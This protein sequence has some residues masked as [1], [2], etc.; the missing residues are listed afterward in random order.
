MINFAINRGNIKSVELENVSLT[1]QELTKLLTLP[2]VTSDKLNAGYFLRCTG[3]K[4]SDK[5]VDDIAHL[6]ILDGDKRYCHEGIEHN[7]AINPQLIHDLFKSEGINHVIYTSHSN[8]VDLYKYRV[9]I[10]VQYRRNQLDAMLWHIFGMLHENELMLVDVK[11]NRAWAQAWFFHSYPADRAHLSQ[12]LVFDSGEDGAFNDGQIEA[13]YAKHQAWLKSLEPPARIFTQS[14]APNV[15]GYTPSIVLTGQINPIEVFN[16]SYSI[17]EI[18][19]ANGYKQ[20]GKRYLH[21][22]STSGIAGVRIL[23]NGKVY[24]DS[25]DALN[26]G[27]AHD[28]FDCFMLLNCGGDRRAALNWNPEITKHNQKIYAHTNAT[29][30]QQND[31]ATAYATGVKYA[32]NE[33][34]S[35]SQFAH[36]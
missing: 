6:L 23:E 17:H 4:R 1:F 16:Q 35:G 31:S 29:K 12:T 9:I 22:N 26:D 36:S 18:L 10:P 34:F 24:S 5:T 13:D 25:N 27:F 20:Q 28:A 19:I 14:Q 11:E 8:D 21:Q 7:G 32:P 3:T 15:E 30:P 33:N 2:K